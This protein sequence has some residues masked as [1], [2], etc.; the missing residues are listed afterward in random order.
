MAQIDVSV[1]PVG[2]AVPNLGC[3]PDVTDVSDEAGVELEFCLIFAP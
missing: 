1:I 3:P 2:N